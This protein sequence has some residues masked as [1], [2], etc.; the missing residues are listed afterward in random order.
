MALPPKPYE[1]IGPVLVR[2]IFRGLTIAAIRAGIPDPFCVDLRGA[3][4]GP[5]FRL[6]ERQLGGQFDR[7]AEHGVSL[8]NEAPTDM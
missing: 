8:R 3:L 2:R 5:T 1:R 4:F 6:E 7:L